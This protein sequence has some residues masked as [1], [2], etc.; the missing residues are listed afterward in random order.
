MILKRKTLLYS[1]FCIFFIFLLFQKVYA[2]Q[3]EYGDKIDV[4]STIDT[5]NR[6]VVIPCKEKVTVLVFLI[7]IHLLISEQSKN[8]MSFS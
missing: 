2:I 1:M 4:I 5:S 7:L 8:L 3:I 6:Q